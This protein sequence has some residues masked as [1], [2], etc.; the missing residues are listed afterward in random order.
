MGVSLIRIKNI[1]R[2]YNEYIKYRDAKRQIYKKKIQK[3][4]RPSSVRRRVKALV[5]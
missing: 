1:L 4:I 3:F 2:N 5:S